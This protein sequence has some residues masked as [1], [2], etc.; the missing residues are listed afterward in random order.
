V[1]FRDGSGIEL[2]TAGE[3]V[4]ELTKRYLEL[5][6][7]G[8]GPAFLALHARDTVRLV[9][10]LR[11]GGYAFSRDGDVIDIQQPPLN[12]LFVV[13]DNRSPTD[14]PE[15]FAH[16]NGATALRAVWIAT[17]GGEELERF[18]VRLGGHSERRTLQAPASATT[19]VVTIDHGEVVILPASHQVVP[20]RP[21]I[22]VS[23]RVSDLDVVNRLLSAA[24]VAFRAEPNA[25]RRVVVPPH[26][27]H[28]VWLEFRQ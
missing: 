11:L 9:T 21:I 14:R 26:Q 23:F 25:P 3:A 12:Y 5:L 28:G 8:E 15:H 13:R 2:L 16:Q 18:L 10:E 17:Q 27:A 6:A 4:D 24:D 1:K 7:T 20:A 22:G 19:T